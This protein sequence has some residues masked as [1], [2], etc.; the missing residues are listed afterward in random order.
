MKDSSM[1]ACQEIE[2]IIIN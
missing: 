2:S 1:R